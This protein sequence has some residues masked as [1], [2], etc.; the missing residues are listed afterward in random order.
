MTAKSTITTILIISFTQ[1]FA[2]QIVPFWQEDFSGGSLPGSWIIEDD[3]PDPVTWE[4]CKDF[5]SCPLAFFSLLDLF[6]DERFNSFSPENGYAYLMPFAEGG[7]HRSYM[8]TPTI[9]CTNKTEVFIS[10]TTFIMAKNSSPD[11][12]AILE[13]RSE[14]NPTWT[15]FTVFPS[16]NT[17][18]VEFDPLFLV[19]GKERIRSY[20]GQ[21]VCIDISGVAAGEDNVEIRWKWEWD[22][23][24]E[25]C[26]LVDDI[27][28]LD[29]NPLDENVVWGNLPGEGD[30]SGGLND[31]TSTVT[32]P[33]TWGWSPDGLVN[34]P[35]DEL[36]NGTACSCTIDDGVALMNAYCSEQI[37][38]QYAE[39]ISPVIDLST[40]SAGKRLGLRFNQSG[41][42]GNNDFSANLPLTSIMISIDGGSTFID[43][44]FQNVTEP[45]RKAFCKNTVL[46][47]PLEVSGSSQFVFKF[48]FSGSSVFWI[49]DDVRI[50]ELHDYDLKI[51][52]DYFSVAEN[53]STPSWM[54]Q[55][56]TFSAEI[57]NLGNLDQENVGVS[58]RIVED[59]SQTT[60]FRDSLFIA[61]ILA[62]DYSESE[63]FPDSFLPEP[64][65]AY[66]AYYEVHSENEDQ[67]PRNNHQSFRFKTD[68]KLLSKNKDKYSMSGGF[69]PSGLALIYEIGTCF[70]IPEGGKVA[71]TGMQFGLDDPF[72]LFE[73]GINL[74][75]NLYK[76]SKDGNKGDVNGDFFAN[77]NEFEK[78]AENFITI[79]EKIFLYE[80]I[81]VPFL[82]EIVFEENTYY[83]VTV[84]YLAPVN[85]APFFIAASEEINYAAT[86]EK[87]EEE[88][89][90]AFVSVLRKGL[91]QDFKMNPWG[92]LRI[93][94]IQLMVDEFTDATEIPQK[95][96]PLKIFPNPTTNKLYMDLTIDEFRG[97][98]AYEIYDICGRLAQPRQTVD[99]YVSQLPIDVSRLDNG[100][101]NLHVIFE[102]KVKVE[103]FVVATQ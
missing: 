59:I 81:E 7:V 56:M 1:V 73:I 78:V 82:D 71:A 87:S 51:N 9:D 5:Q 93:P 102:D 86:F 53:Y 85:G 89:R 61:T 17:D 57:Q 23:E 8:Q 41:I 52:E 63:S 65:M 95:Q 84:E 44:I 50:V 24:D 18:Q 14:N 6:P 19:E 34:F 98:L 90:P 27:Q 66:T 20:N 38:D 43:T 74:G 12:D 55:P 96:F 62:G 83:F 2:K 49:V 64:N 91:E 35:D 75:V 31:W 4:L 39:L 80:N 76:W 88:G 72:D 11:Q 13:V 16:L 15:P 70:F 3:S 10:F 100:I 48:I 58:L 28:L 99:G 79:N 22:G 97:G 30:F 60:V 26:W 77:T 29:V 54:I 101:Y 47:L 32:D 25:F 33:C 67:D 21:Y 42:K 37:I 40:V 92:L 46:P 94:Y 69:A 45:F 68:R 103:K 36:A